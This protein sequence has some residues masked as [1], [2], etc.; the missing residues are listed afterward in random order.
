MT[1]SRWISQDLDLLPDD[2]KRYE[3]VDGELYVSKQPLLE[4]MLVNIGL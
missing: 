1:T 3:I 4:T 2:G